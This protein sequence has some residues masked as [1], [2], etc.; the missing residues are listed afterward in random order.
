[1]PPI[2][3]IGNC[4]KPAAS[5][6]C[7]KKR[8]AIGLTAFPEKPEIEDLPLT[9]GRPT[10]RSRS[11]LATDLTVLIVAIPS[12]PPAKLAF[13]AGTISVILGVK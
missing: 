1:M 9:M 8:S 4:S 10:L 6:N 2:P 13:A 3:E 7:C 5:R 11:I 12:A